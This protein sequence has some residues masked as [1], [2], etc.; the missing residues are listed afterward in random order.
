MSCKNRELH[1]G[2]YLWS[3]KSLKVCR[4]IYGTPR[5]C[6][7]FGK[8]S[9]VMNTKWWTQYYSFHVSTNYFS[10]KQ[11]WVF[12]R[13]IRTMWWWGTRRL[14]IQIIRRFLIQ[15]IRRFLRVIERTLFLNT[16][17]THSTEEKTWCE[18]K[19]ASNFCCHSCW[20]VWVSFCSFLL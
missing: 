5:F 2:I 8:T 13:L 17:K 15:I 4:Y 18:R 6:I 7:L 16:G 9:M 1:P 12:K 19:M 10:N 14:L 20:W 3:K 11:I